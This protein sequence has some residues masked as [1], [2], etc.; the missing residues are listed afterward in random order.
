MPPQDNTPPGPL[1]EARLFHDLVC[2]YERYIH[3]EQPEVAA[4]CLRTLQK[5]I[6]RHLEKPRTPRPERDRTDTNR[7]AQ[8]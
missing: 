2:D 8:G 4:E 5:A 1:K 3:N 7:A 6:E